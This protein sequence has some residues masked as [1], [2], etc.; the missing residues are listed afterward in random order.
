MIT[1]T[2][3][4]IID[5]IETMKSLMNEPLPSRVAFQVA[6]LAQNMA[7]EYKYFEDTRL[8]LIQKY[9]E[10]DENGELL[11]DSN[12]QYKISSDKAQEFSKEI[13]DLMSSSVELVN[14]KINIDDL[15]CDLTP[16]EMINLMPFL[17]ENNEEEI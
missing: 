2:L 8:K 9:G 5:S 7:T 4:E 3:R 17:E 1:V 14:S 11:I 15:T 13:E 12:N 6:K 16:N 10:K